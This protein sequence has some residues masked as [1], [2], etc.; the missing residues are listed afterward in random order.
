MYASRFRFLVA[1]SLISH[2][3]QEFL[4]YYEKENGIKSQMV[5]RMKSGPRTYVIR[6]LLPVPFLP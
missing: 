4:F 5:E 2:H 6:T 3:R 1:V